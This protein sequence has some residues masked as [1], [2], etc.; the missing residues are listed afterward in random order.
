MK[1]DKEHNRSI[2]QGNNVPTAINGWSIFMIL[3]ANVYVDATG[4]RMIVVLIN[5]VMLIF[6]AVCL[7]AWDIP[8]GLRIVSYLFAGTDGPLSP[9]YMS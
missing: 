5:L 9:I 8:L 3:A 6:G 4:R 2:Y 1:I 7:I